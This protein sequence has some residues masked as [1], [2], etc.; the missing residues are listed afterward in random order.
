MSQVNTIQDVLNVLLNGGQ[1]DQASCTFFFDKIMQGEVSDIQLS[2]AL[3]ALKVRGETAEEIAGAAIAM[4]NNALPFSRPD[5]DFVDSCGTGGDGSN[6]F[7]ISTTAAIVAASCGVKVAKHGNR[8]VSSQSGSSDLLTEL[9]INLTMSPEVARTCLDETG[10]TFLFAPHYHQ[11][12]KHAMPVRTGLKIRTLFNLLGPLINPAA[13]NFQLMGVYDPALIKTIAH[14]LQNLGVEQAMVVNGAGL[15]EMAIHGETQVAHLRNHTITEY[16]LS[17][18]D[19]GLST[20]T[21]TD[22][23]GGS[24]QQN[25][26]ITKAI[27]AGKGTEAH[28][29]VIA[30]NVAPLLVMLGL[31]ASYKAASSFV[32]EVLQSGKPMQL[33]AEFAELSHSGAIKQ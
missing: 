9:G 17:P 4:K 15:D 24:P 16:T 23:E 19:F 7:N 27:L 5:Y 6:T 2:A 14:T 29:A 26:L 10:L 3:S 20:Y 8:S 11:G 31:Q 13:P 28:N 30:I 21:L 18:S 33:L 22:I 32:L 1:L 12:V 25:A